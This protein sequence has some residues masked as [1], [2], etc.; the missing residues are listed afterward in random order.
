MEP[1][2]DFAEVE[3]DAAGTEL[4][5]GHAALEP[6]V[7]G[8]SGETEMTRQRVLVDVRGRWSWLFVDLEWCPDQELNLDPR[9]R[10]PLL[11]PFE[12]SGRGAADQRGK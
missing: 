1:G 10:K 7:D 6:V 11:Y 12:L 4:E 3:S 9:F 5:V 2:F 8:A